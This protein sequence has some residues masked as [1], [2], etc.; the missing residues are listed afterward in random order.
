M[1]SLEHFLNRYL[2]KIFVGVG[3][4]LVLAIAVIIFTIILTKGF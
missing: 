1:I 3:L 2:N 4:V